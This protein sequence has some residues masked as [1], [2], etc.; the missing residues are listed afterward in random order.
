M[1]PADLDPSAKTVTYTLLGAPNVDFKLYR[2]NLT[3]FLLDETKIDPTRFD[4]TLNQPTEPAPQPEQP[5]PAPEPTPQPEPAP[6]SRK[7]VI[8]QNDKYQVVIKINEAPANLPL[9]IIIGVI[10][11]VALIIT[12]VDYFI[13]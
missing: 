7:R 6:A 1:D 8:S 9:Y 2:D 5:Q 11:A 13:E 10:S 12:V 3:Q 4:I